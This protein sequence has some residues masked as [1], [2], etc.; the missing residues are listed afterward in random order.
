VN[1]HVYSKTGQCHK[2]VFAFITYYLKLYRS[3]ITICAYYSYKT[4][5]VISWNIK[6]A[7]RNLFII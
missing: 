1:Q 6:T 2:V 3:N 5:E 7:K 4:V